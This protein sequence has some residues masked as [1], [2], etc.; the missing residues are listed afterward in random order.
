MRTISR[1]HPEK[2]QTL[3]KIHLVRFLG[4]WF[5]E[6]PTFSF[7]LE[8]EFD[9]EKEVEHTSMCFDRNP[10]GKNIKETVLT[11]IK[12]KFSERE[13]T[14]DELMAELPCEI[15]VDWLKRILTNLVKLNT[16]SKVGNTKNTKYF[17]TKEGEILYSNPLEIALHKEKDWSSDWSIPPQIILQSSGEYSNQYANEYANPNPRPTR[18]SGGLEYSI[19]LN[20]P[21]IFWEQ[22]KITNSP[23]EEISRCKYCGEPITWGKDTETGQWLPMRP[24]YKGFHRCQ[25]E[26][27]H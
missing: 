14:R 27:K 2:K 13:F 24:D 7:W 23:P 20:T 15:S 22:E 12:N 10:E 25:K 16:I 6:F 19:P 4:G 18:L 11:T 9:E 17:F 26:V 1:F 8:D 21:K 5:P 3:Q